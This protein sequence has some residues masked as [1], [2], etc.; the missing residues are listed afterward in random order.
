MIIGDRVVES[1]PVWGVVQTPLSKFI[2]RYDYTETRKIKTKSPRK[3]HKFVKSQL[4]KTYDWSAYFSFFVRKRY[5]SDHDEWMCSELIAAATIAAGDNYFDLQVNYKIT[6][7]NLYY[8]F[9]E[10]E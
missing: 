4:G 8:L 10:N 7:D 6:P 5:L 2:S 9:K 1:R 3:F